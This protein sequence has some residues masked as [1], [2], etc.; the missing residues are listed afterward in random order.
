MD[1]FEAFPFA[2]VSGV[3]ELGAK[4]RSTETGTTFESL[5]GFDVIIDD[6]ANG[7]IPVAQNAE[8]VMTDS[9]IY[10]RASDLPSLNPA[11]YL[12]DYLWFNSETE[13]YYLI[14]NVGVGKNQDNGKIEHLEF[15][16]RPTEIL[17]D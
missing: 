2:I 15:Q 16:I 4:T 6:D 1:V 13:T 11:V 3:W 14:V 5:G 8:S 12:S 7:G 10:A 9:L 17:D